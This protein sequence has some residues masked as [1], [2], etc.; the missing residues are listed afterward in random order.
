MAIFF[1]SNRGRNFGIEKLKKQDDEQKKGKIE[2]K[3]IEE[4]TVKLNATT[5]QISPD[6]MLDFISQ[7]AIVNTINLNVKNV[8]VEKEEKN[9]E[10][11]KKSLKEMSLSEL[12]ELA[13][14]MESKLKDLRGQIENLQPPVEPL[15]EQFINEDGILDKD[16]YESAVRDFVKAQSE[17]SQKILQMYEEIRE[18]SS[19]LDAVN[20]EIAEKKIKEKFALYSN[21]L[22]GLDKDS[23]VDK[24]ILKLLKEELESIFKQGV[25]LPAHLLDMKFRLEDIYERISIM[26]PPGNPPQTNS[27]V[28]SDGSFDEEAYNDAYN[29]YMKELEDYDNEVAR[30]ENSAN[31]LINEINKIQLEI[32]QNEFKMEQIGSNITALSDLQGIIDNIP[33]TPESREILTE[34]KKKMSD[35]SINIEGQLV[36]NNKLEELSKNFLD[37]PV[38]VPPSVGD[39]LNKDGTADEEAYTKAY[40]EYEKAVKEYDKK[41]DEFNKQMSS[42][43]KELSELRTAK[44]K[45]LFGANV[46]SVKNKIQNLKNEG[47]Y[48]EASAL[49][50]KLKEL[51]RLYNNVLRHKKGLEKREEILQDKLATLFKDLTPPEIND[52]SD[53][54]GNIDER[55][56]SKAV[57]EYNE[58]ME[59]ENKISEKI[60]AQLDVIYQAYEKL[61]ERKNKL[62]ENINEL[63][64]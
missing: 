10:L 18:L 39:F 25:D 48:D 42:L 44:D 36:L 21:L 33:D 4:K 34:L 27:F 52:Y 5:R 24:D 62:M 64:Y 7:N 3:P 13:Q 8:S 57:A 58:R 51:E 54:Y 19:K 32:E 29:S 35:L 12:K 23:D 17:Y 15:E 11:P 53:V 16:S 2:E 63:T 40:N 46:L 1:E 9:K 26:L 14:N 31:A 55:A 37:S 50:K 45:T 28:N 6:T 41:M 47:H 38:P 20:K 43:N 61:D 22:N 60:H 30:L 49:D 59:N 56:Y